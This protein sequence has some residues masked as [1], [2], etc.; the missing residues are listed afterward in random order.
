MRLRSFFDA[1]DLHRDEKFVSVRFRRPFRVI[2]TSG[3]SGGIAENLDLVF[4]HQSC[5]PKSH[6]L[7]DLVA[8]HRDAKTYVRVLTERGGVPGAAAAGLGTAANMNNL[9]IAEES[10]RELSVAALATGGVETNAARAGDPAAFYE[11]DGRFER[12]RGEEAALP[13]GTINLIVLVNRPL[14]DGALV[15]AVMTATEAKTAVL[16]E[17]SVASRQSAGLATGTGTDQIAIAAPAEGAT[18]LTSAGHHAVLGEL[19]GRTVHDALAQ[20]LAFQNRLAPLSQGSAGRLLE[21]FGLAA[22]DFIP[23]VAELLPPETAAL[24]RANRLVIDREPMT[25]AAV[26]A[27]VHIHDQIAWGM[28]PPLCWR[29]AAVG[30]GALI[31]AAAAGRTDLSPVFREGLARAVDA[32][33]RDDPVFVAVHAAA[34]GYAEKWTSTEAMLA[35]A[36][37]A[38][39]GGC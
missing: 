19:I 28:L 38:R 33:D 22:D 35:G 36:L 8:A 16:Q 2:S 17:R 29:E 21:R 4:N 12:C 23:R 10:F 5:E 34:L 32:A 26:A 11:C 18:P 20:T 30:H 27:L 1:I 37:A 15:R 13:H 7:P 9:C 3:A 6:N 24:A 14:A 31:A 39:E 25:V